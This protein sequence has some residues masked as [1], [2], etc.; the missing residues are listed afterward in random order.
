MT[1]QPIG[2][3]ITRFQTAREEYVDAAYKW[4]ELSVGILVNLGIRL[5][6]PLVTV[7]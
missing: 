2:K 6:V 4:P 7:T 3:P 1:N 5:S